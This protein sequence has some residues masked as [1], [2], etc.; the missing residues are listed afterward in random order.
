M[1]WLM[2]LLAVAVCCLLHQVFENWKLQAENKR[3]QKETAEA[4][5]LKDV[6]AAGMAYIVAY[7]GGCLEVPPGAIE[8]K[9]KEIVQ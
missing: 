4:Q 5:Q 2:W 8:F 3:L 9:T 1:D 7:Q 6:F